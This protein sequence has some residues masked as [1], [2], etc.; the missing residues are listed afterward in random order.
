MENT[1]LWKYCTPEQ[2]REFLLS[3]RLLG[4]TDREDGEHWPAF[5]LSVII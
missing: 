1:G 5:M 4:R 3:L 2:S